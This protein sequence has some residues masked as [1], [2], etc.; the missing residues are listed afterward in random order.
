MDVINFIYDISKK[1]NQDRAR[2]FLDALARP[3]DDEAR[4]A[5][6]AFFFGTYAHYGASKT[7]IDDMVANRAK[8]AASMP[9]PLY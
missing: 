1:E 6:T 3:T 4:G 8:L 5:L 2:E 7:D 9:I